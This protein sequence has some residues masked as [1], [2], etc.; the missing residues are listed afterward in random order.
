MKCWLPD[1]IRFIDEVPQTSVGK[2]DKNVL[3]Q[4]RYCT[5]SI[6]TSGS[7]RLP[8]VRFTTVYL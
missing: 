5:G 3:R 8:V 6:M 7:F 4:R 2:F 1:K